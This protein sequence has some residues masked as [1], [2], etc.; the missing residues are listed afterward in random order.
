L[1]TSIEIDTVSIQ[2]LFGQILFFAG[3][4]SFTEVKSIDVFCIGMQCVKLC[5]MNINF[6]K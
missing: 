3:F 5:F 2:P 6:E 1:Y 4:H